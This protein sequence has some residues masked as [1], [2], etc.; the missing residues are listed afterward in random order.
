MKYMLDTNIC[1]YVQKNKNPNVLKKF[2]ENFSQLGISVITYAELLVGVENSECKEKNAESLEKLVKYL[3]I[4]PFDVNAAKE[5]AN[6][7]A[8]LE[9]SGNRIGDND[10]LIAAN[11]KA[12]NAIL[13]TN[14]VREFERVDGLIVE[15][16]VL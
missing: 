10:M 16:W 4:T 9:K 15:N 3:E 14:N 6:I 13:V 2:K 7:R 1:I 11:A 12:E 8:K 5:Y